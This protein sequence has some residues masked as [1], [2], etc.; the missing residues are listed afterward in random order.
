ME[1]SREVDRADAI[2]R[3]VRDFSR[4]APYDPRDVSLF[5]VTR[6]AMQ[7]VAHDARKR[8][9]RME[10]LIDPRLPGVMVDSIQIQQ[11]LVN[12][13]QNAFD[14]MEAISESSRLITI[15]AEPREGWLDVNVRDRGPG[16]D[17]RNLE[18][19]F[20]PFVT[21]KAQGLGMGLAISRGIL[22][23][24]GGKLVA[25]P[26]GGEGGHFRFTLPMRESR[27]S[28]DD[29]IRHADPTHPPPAPHMGRIE[30]RGITRREE[31]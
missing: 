11:V 18:R 30:S 4:Q 10:C 24:H 3:R 22:V 2:L 19:F 12:L 5:D 27:P 9:C 7:L 16:V 21:T 28:S 23:A 29:P 25:V 31:R 20:E 1:I 15:D 13:L 8:G 6:E 26:G 14:A 17:P